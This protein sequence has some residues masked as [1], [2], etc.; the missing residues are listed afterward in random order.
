MWSH[1]GYQYHSSLITKH[2]LPLLDI[3]KQ[4]KIVQIGSGLGIAVEALCNIFGPSRVIG[5]DLF[6]PLHH[7]NIEFLDTQTTVP[8]LQELAYLE[9]DVGSMSDARKN[10][11]KLLDWALGSMV[12]GGHILTNRKLVVE[13]QKAGVKNFEVIDLSQFDVPQLWTNVYETRLNTKV[14]LKVNK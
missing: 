9:I 8:P 1:Y 6:N 7:P 10:R 4:G 2:I 3:P 5:Y 12:D 13:L 11:K 14:I